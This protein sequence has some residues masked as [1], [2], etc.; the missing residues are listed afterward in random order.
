MDERR[1]ASTPNNEPARRLR[2]VRPVRIPRSAGSLL[3]VVAA[4]L[5]FGW[6]F[7]GPSA[8]EE[9]AEDR[10]RAELRAW[11]TPRGKELRAATDPHFQLSQRIAQCIGLNLMDGNQPFSNFMAFWMW[12]QPNGSISAPGQPTAERPPLLNTY[13]QGLVYL[14]AATSTARGDAAAELSEHSALAIMLQWVS[15]C[16]GALATILVTI[17]STAG[18]DAPWGKVAG[19]LAVIC[20]GVVT[21]VTGMNAF[22][23]SGEAAARAQRS[24]FQL[25]ELHHD[26]AFAVVTARDVCQDLD[27]RN[28]ELPDVRDLRAFSARFTSA[29]QTSYAPA[30]GTQPGDGGAGSKQGF[31]GTR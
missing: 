18:G 14:S 25:R 9:R 11:E 3:A 26:M 27:V 12:P 2:F 19:W 28:P 22:Y 31:P 13:Q 6:W 23:G 29:M 8:A 20:S 17:K 30:P 15:V 1:T 7:L 16:L 5:A 10:R 4:A 21:I 24:L